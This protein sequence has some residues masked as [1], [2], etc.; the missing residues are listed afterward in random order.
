MLS[1]SRTSV[2]L[3]VPVLASL[4]LGSPVASAQCFGPDGLDIG[5]CCASILPTLPAFPA[6]GMGGLNICF[7]QCNTTATRTLK[8]SWGV[9]VQPFCGEF[10]APLTVTDAGSGAPMLVGTLVLDYTRTWTEIDTAGIPTQ[11]WRF[12]AKADLSTVPGVAVLPCSS[13]GCIVPVGPHP[14]AFYYGYADYS[15]CTAAG[16]WSSALV[17]Y[18]A[19]DRFIH[20]PGLSDKPGVFHPTAAFAIVAPHDTVQPFVPANAIAGSGPVFGEATR[21]VNTFTPPPNPCTVEDRVVQAAMTKLGAGCICTLAKNPKQQTLRKFDGTTN[22]VNAAGLPGGWASLAVAFPV[23][24]WFHLITT[25]IGSWS[26]PNVYPG[27]EEAWVD[28]GLFVHQSACNGDFVELKYGG[29]TRGGFMAIL[30][31]PVLVTN[32]TDLADNYTAPLFG[33]YPSPILGSVQ[34]TDHLIYVNEP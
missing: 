17:L 3:A 2:L 1:A 14:T 32:F 25:S 7:T 23:L 5:P 4:L 33:P 31:V 26:N 8:V 24:P 30:P 20:A 16:P 29:S 12:V 10:T 18:H 27:N 21:D 11:V 6:V 13:P 15:S 34:P 22:C 19:C 9:P 28:E